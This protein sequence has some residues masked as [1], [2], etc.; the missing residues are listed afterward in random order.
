MDKKTVLQIIS[1]ILVS[2]LVFAAFVFAVTRVKPLVGVAVP[3]NDIV[4]EPP[5]DYPSNTTIMFT[6][7]DGYSLCVKFE[8]EKSF[9]SALFL[10]NANQKAFENF[11]FFAT[12]TVNFSYKSLMDFIDTIDGINLD[13]FGEEM[14]YTGV[15]VC[16]IIAV[17]NDHIET[18]TKILKAVF[19]KIYKIGFSSDALYCIM[20]NTDNTLSVPDCYGWTEYLGEMCNRYNIVNEE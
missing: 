7:E 19:N 1:V 16:N 8:F 6:F 11:G 5:T 13:I 15:Q 10:E 3:K 18:K 9:I 14:R 2:A 4:Y 17:N 12:E 20:N